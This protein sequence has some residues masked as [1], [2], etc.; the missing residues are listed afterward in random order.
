MWLLGKLKLHMN[1]ADTLFLLAAQPWVPAALG[2][3]RS[4]ATKKGLLKLTSTLFTGPLLTEAQLGE[5]VFVSLPSA[6]E[7]KIT[8]F[9]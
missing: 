3:C 4:G 6:P 8:A 7:G 1:M 9:T 5:V 2:H